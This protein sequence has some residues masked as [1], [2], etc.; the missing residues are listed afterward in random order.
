M[1]RIYISG[2]ITGHEDYLAEFAL[3][4]DKVKARF[5]GK[6][7]IINPARICANLPESTG[8]EEY[9]NIC[10]A[11]VEMATVIYM[12]PGWKE[13]AGACVEYGYARALGRKIYNI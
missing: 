12:M 9:M 8:W 6:V 4:E 11:L 1:E 2:P 7:E 10:L 3:M 5:D 13:S